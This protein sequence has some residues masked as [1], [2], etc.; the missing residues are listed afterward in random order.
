MRFDTLLAEVGIGKKAACKLPMFDSEMGLL[1]VLEEQGCLQEAVLCVAHLLPPRESVWWACQL[2]KDQNAELES[3]GKDAL[4]AAEQ[5]A[6]KPTEENR[7]KAAK[8]AELAGMD[9][10]EGMAAM[11]ARFSTGSVVENS[12]VK[13][14]PPEKLYAK[15]SGGAVLLAMLRM[16]P[17]G[18]PFLEEAL[19]TGK[20]VLKAEN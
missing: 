7:Q 3:E 15:M 2:L 19:K 5:W 12:G 11:A 9:T 6:L 20:T 13:L 1:E 17:D 14:P 8:L 4:I 10:P 16:L 18:E